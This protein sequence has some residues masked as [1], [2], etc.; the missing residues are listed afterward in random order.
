MYCNQKLRF[1]EIILTLN[2]NMTENPLDEKPI[3][4]RQVWRHY[5]Q[6]RLKFVWKLISLHNT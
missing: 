6:H 5:A 2:Q 4:E 3:D 1:F